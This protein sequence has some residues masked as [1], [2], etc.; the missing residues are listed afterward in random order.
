M[1]PSL[2]EALRLPAA[3]NYSPEA[4]VRCSEAM[5]ELQ[6]V[7]TELSEHRAAVAHRHYAGHPA[8]LAR[9][10]GIHPASAQRIMTRATGQRFNR[11]ARRAAAAKRQR[12]RAEHKEEV[13]S[14]AA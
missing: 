2:H 11:N 13:L 12:T 10:L 5:A 4:V 3:D 9:A 7:I 8:A 14:D 1:S 6:A